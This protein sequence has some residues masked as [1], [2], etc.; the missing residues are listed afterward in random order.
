M[1]DFPFTDQSLLNI[2]KEEGVK[3]NLL[4]NDNTQ[5][6]ALFATQKKKQRGSVFV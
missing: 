4:I 3:D 2:A 1:R 5:I 6:N